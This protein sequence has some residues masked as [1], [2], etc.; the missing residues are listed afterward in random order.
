MRNLL[1]PLVSP[2]AARGWTLTAVETNI[3]APIIQVLMALFNHHS[4][5]TEICASLPSL[6]VRKL[7]P[8]VILIY[9]YSGHLQDN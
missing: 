3:I 8:N 2:E 7:R 5:P 6:Q 1:F 9:L 4:N